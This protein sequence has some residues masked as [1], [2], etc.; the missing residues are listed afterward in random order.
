MKGYNLDFIDI[1]THKSADLWRVPGGEIQ[2]SPSPGSHNTLKDADFNLFSKSVKFESTETKLVR[3]KSLMP[4]FST[5]KHRLRLGIK[6]NEKHKQ[7]SLFS[8]CIFT[9]YVFT[10]LYCTKTIICFYLYPD[11]SLRQKWEKYW[12]MKTK[13]IDQIIKNCLEPHFCFLRSDPHEV[14]DGN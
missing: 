12:L 13:N 11:Y 3:N 7:T 4:L 9:P 5:G 8:C 14:S 6:Q 10:E 2:V 1:S